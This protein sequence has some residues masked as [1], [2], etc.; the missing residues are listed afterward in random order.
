MDTK[1]ALCC[2]TL[3]RVT[4]NR[5]RRRR[6]RLGRGDPAM[7]PKLP[8]VRWKISRRTRQNRTVCSAPCTQRRRWRRSAGLER[9]MPASFHLA[10]SLLSSGG[11]SAPPPIRPVF[12]YQPTSRHNRRKTV[13]N[14]LERPSHR[15]YADSEHDSVG[16]RWRYGRHTPIRYASSRRNMF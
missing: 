9:A 4:V 1:G 12:P 14:F 8:R 6:R 10:S 2:R 3:Q 15:L 7:R 11:Q 13:G 5:R 16:G